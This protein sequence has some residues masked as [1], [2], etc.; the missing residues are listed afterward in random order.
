MSIGC[1]SA[2]G[3]RKGIADGK[4]SA[5]EI[6]VQY[7]ER[8]KSKDSEIGAFITICEEES[9]KQARTVDNKRKKGE[10]LGRLAGV[11][12]AIK[13]NICTNGIRTTCASKMLEDFIP[14]YNA[15]VVDRLIMEDAVILGKTNM[16]EFGMGSSNEN[17]AFKITRNPRDTGRVPG[18]SSGG[19]AAAVAADMV[20]ASLGSDTGGSIRQ[21]AAFCGVVGLKPTYGLVSRFGL[22]AFGSSLDTIGPFSKTVRDCAIL[23]DVIQGGDGK[24]STSHTGHYEKDYIHCMDGTVE[25]LKICVPEEFFN[26]GLDREIF[27]LVKKSAE[28]L[29]DLG[30]KVEEVSMPV[31]SQSLPAFYIIS[32]AEAS[33]NL[34]RYDGIRYGYRPEEYEN[35]DDLIEKSRTEAFGDEVK[36]RI[37]FGTCVLTSGYYEEYY[38]GA[39]KIR[40]ILCDQFDELFSKYDIILGPVS[41][42][43]PFKIGESPKNPIDRYLADIYTAT[44]NLAGIPAISVPCGFS[45]EGLPVGLQMMGPRFGEKRI[46]QAAYALEQAL[47]LK[48]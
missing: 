7:L 41:P 9:I 20:P 39:L 16:D 47:Q 2:E 42:V 13:D 37:M 43:L 31:I 18:G 35:L 28:I 26:E 30:A 6:T 17:S 29:K 4:F 33:S 36:R 40:R 48:L 38:V 46:L 8:I 15:T 19:S 5:E 34:G 45:S 24:D 14:P 21:P 1:M 32:S 27:Q 11:P 22:I 23:L 25:G 12:I 3:I 10:P 44:A